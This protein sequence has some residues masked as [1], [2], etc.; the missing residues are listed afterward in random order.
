MIT[1]FTF[2]PA[3]GLPDSSPFV[4]KAE[5]LLKM[6]GLEYRTDPG[7]FAGAPKGKLPYLKDGG[8]LVADST[9]IRWHVEKKYGVDFD[10]HLT[11]A[12]RGVAWAVEKLL[13][14]NLYWAMVDA[15][16]MTPENFA[17]GPAHF[18]D[19]LPAPLRPL[20]RFVVRRKVRGYLKGQ[21]F[22]RHTRTEVERLGAK[23]L[24]SVSA[25]LGDKPYLMGSQP[26][27][28]DA[29]LFAFVLGVQCPVFDTPVRA[30]AE[31]HANL[32]AYTQRLLRQYYPAFAKD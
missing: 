24:E 9:F 28:A 6:A 8:E 21:G 11:V 3:F 22:G 15:R 5:T 20:V 19:E 12:E 30:A 10:K 26:C 2:G 17:R 25:V 31:S 32:A 29:T 13:E 23:A 14:D 4:M 18:F 7:G 27:A 16:W 1:L